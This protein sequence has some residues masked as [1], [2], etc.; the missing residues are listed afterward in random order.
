MHKASRFIYLNTYSFLLLVCGIAAA[1]APLYQIS[2]LLIIPQVIICFICFKQSFRL[3]STW[4][5]KKRKYD[6][7]MERN[8]EHFRPDTFETYMQAPCGRLL[9]KAVLKD[10]G[11][12]K[13]YRELLVY[14]VPLLKSLKQNC[15]PKKT[16]VYI[17]ENLK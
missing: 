17:N 12:S 8:K 15:T 1:L 4:G 11:E 6:L 7:L 9:A 14:R 5:E 2:K 3:F 10:L 16:R 13:R